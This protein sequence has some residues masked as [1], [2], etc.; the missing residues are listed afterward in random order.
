MIEPRRPVALLALGSAVPPYRVEQAELADWMAESLQADRKL[1]RWLRYL[2]GCSG[3]DTRYSCLPDASSSPALS[4][5]AP[6][7]RLDEAPTTA[8]RMAIYKREA[9]QVGTAA[10]RDTLH[11]YARTANRDDG[12]ADAVTHLIV[13]SCTGFFAPGLDHAIARELGLRATV[14]RTLVGFMGCAAAFNALRLAAQIVQ[15]DPAA[16]VLIVC[17]ELCSLHIQPG[18]DRVNL[19]VTSLF[20]DGAAACLVG[21]SAPD[22]RE[23]FVIG[24]FHTTLEPD[25]QSDM[26]WDIGDHG[27]TMH[28]SPRIPARLGEAAPRALAALVG[29]RRNLEFWAIHPGGR[30]IVDA[31]ATIFALSPEQT[32][33]TRHVLRNYGNMS[34]PTILFVLQELRARLRQRPG[35]AVQDGVAMAFGPGLV[36]EMAQL[37]YVPAATQRSPLPFSGKKGAA[38]EQVA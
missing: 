32:A 28:L 10:A 35:A 24:R 37:R 6:H 38:V 22:D 1:A 7:R 29:N 34:S 31:L 3:I 25:S 27:F 14:E 33:A 18:M 9:V 21:S 15:G 30:A 8:E 20:A 17:V 13:V 2:Y 4:R 12:V 16:L 5:F 36:I 19:V 26:V 11:D 23:H